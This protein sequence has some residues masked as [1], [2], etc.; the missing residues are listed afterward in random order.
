MRGS[1]IHRDDQIQRG[2]ERGGAGEVGDFR[3]EIRDGRGI[4]RRRE[5]SARPDLQAD[6]TNVRY[7][8]ERG[9]QG[10]RKGAAAV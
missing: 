8:E 7:R 6:E 5:R 4:E 10:G 1:G 3:R 9:Q 2:D